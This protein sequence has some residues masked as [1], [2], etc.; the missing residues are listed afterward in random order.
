MAKS[1]QKP[2]TT[3]DEAVEALL[4]KKAAKRLRK[5]ANEL[6]EAGEDALKK[7]R[8]K[9]KKVIVDID[10]SCACSYRAT[11]VRVLLA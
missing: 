10:A 5:L 7:R 1:T 11:A 4:G 9:R 6:A 2:R 8:K 3:T